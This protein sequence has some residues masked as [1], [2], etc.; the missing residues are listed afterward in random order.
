MVSIKC[1]KTHE[2][3]KYHFRKVLISFPWSER[4]VQLLLSRPANASVKY[5][6]AVAPRPT[7]IPH[8]LR[9]HLS[10][11]RRSENTM[12]ELVGVIDSNS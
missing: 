5:H 4:T 9:L 6:A 10:H 2:S 7:L 11:F 1:R 8:W 3:T 12:V